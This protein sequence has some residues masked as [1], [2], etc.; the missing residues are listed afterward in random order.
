MTTIDTPH[1]TA[2]PV[3]TPRLATGAA[4]LVLALTAMFSTL[5]EPKD[6]TTGDALRRFYEDN[7]AATG[8]AVLGLTL[9]MIAF[10]LFLVGLRRLLSE[11]GAERSTIDLMTV[12]GT[13]VTLWFWVEAATGSMVSVMA[14]DSGRLS[15]YDDQALAHLDLFSRF[16]ETFADIG[17]ALTGL[18]VASVSLAAIR[19]RFMP[20]WIGHV[21][22]V[23]AAGCA[24]SLAGIAW[25]N[26]VSTTGFFVGLLGFFL[27]TLMTA[28]A[29]CVRGLRRTS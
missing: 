15:E 27:W 18:F 4:G 9:S 28:V 22:L 5:P 23:V 11:A 19:T 8:L 25:V 3:R 16:S 17:L 20:R 21:G 13:L 7:L 2:S 6:G 1:E 24:V 26:P 29:L 12:S 10:V 14:N